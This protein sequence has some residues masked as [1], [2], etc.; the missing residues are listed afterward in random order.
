MA[1]KDNRS[2]TIG[3]IKLYFAHFIGKYFGDQKIIHTFAL[4]LRTRVGRES[5]IER[6]SP[7]RFE[8]KTW[9]DGRVA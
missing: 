1:A 2:S 6:I 4:R 3:S 7:L 8:I 9:S 5:R